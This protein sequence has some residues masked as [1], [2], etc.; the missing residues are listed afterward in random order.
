M[1]LFNEPKEDEIREFLK[2]QANALFSHR[3]VGATRN[4]ASVRGFSSQHCRTHLGVGEAAFR[5]AAEALRLW[6]MFDLD[7]VRA[8]FP[9][10]P[11]EGAVVGVLVRHF[12]FWSLN[13]ARIVY[14]ID[15]PAR[16][17]FAYGTLEEHAESGEEKFLVERD[18]TTGDVWYEIASFSRP[19]QILAWLGYPLTRLLQK[20]FARDSMAA[21]RRAVASQ[22]R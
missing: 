16:F 6:R 3:A 1:F 12:G 20:R 22:A 9:P 8:C 14:V 19:N 7:W 4:G 18:S 11:R 21:M 2:R 17:G 13:G 5:S 10:P 15:E